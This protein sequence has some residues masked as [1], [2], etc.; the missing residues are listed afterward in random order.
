MQL[1]LMLYGT[2]DMILD[3]IQPHGSSV[4]RNIDIKENLLM[5]IHFL[6]HFPKVSLCNNLWLLDKIDIKCLVTQWSGSFRRGVPIY[7]LVGR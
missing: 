4:I 7:L 1:A 3:M 6:F 2:L 5:F